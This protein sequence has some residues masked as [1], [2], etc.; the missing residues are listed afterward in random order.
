MVYA[1][2]M[3]AVL[4]G[5]LLQIEQDGPLAPS[6]LFCFFVAAEFIIAALLHP[7]EFKCLFCIVVYY[8]TIPSMYLLLVI[9]SVFNLNNVAWGTR[10][11]K[12]K[13]TKLVGNYFSFLNLLYLN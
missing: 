12:A 3:M 11:V 13:L 6:S 7:V 10:E 8:V 5:I 9:Y 4:V 2:V 1:L